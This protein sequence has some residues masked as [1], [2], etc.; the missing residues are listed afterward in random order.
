MHAIVNHPSRTEALNVI[1]E[2]VRP[3]LTNDMGSAIEIYD[4][5]GNEGMGPPPHAHDWS[6]TY[7]MLAGELD[8]MIGGDEPERLTAGMVAHA[9][10]GTAHGYRIAADD[11]RFL[12]ILSQGNGHEFFRQMDAEVSFPP[13]LED[14]RPDRDGARHPVPIVTTRSY[15]SPQR[16]RT[17][18][19]HPTEA[20]STPSAISSSRVGGQQPVALGGGR[21]GRLLG[22]GRCTATSPPGRAGSRRW[23]STSRPS[24]TRSRPTR[25]T[26]PRIFPALLPHD[27]PGGA[28]QPDRNRPAVPVGRPTGATIRAQASGRPP[29]RGEASRSSAIDAPGATTPKTRSRCAARAGRGR[30][31]P[32][33]A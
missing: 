31:L 25:R 26:R 14:V 27:P 19:G 1:G 21:S 10:A 13:E 11:T 8:V 3:L 16:D 4:T 9:P 30:V 7:V 29:R 6:E 23:P 12:T 22:A 24:C 20:S 5:E 28:G 2:T 15:L 17:G 33:H 32:R 18:C